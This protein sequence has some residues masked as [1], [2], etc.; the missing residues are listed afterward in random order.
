ML[1]AVHTQTAYSIKDTSGPAAAL[2]YME[3]KLHL[4]DYLPH[5]PLL[6]WQVLAEMSMANGDSSRASEI[7][8][9]IL[10]TPV[11]HVDD[12]VEPDVRSWAENHRQGTAQRETKSSGCFIA[13]AVYGN[14]D[15]SQVALLRQFRDERLV[16]TPSGRLFIR[17]YYSFSPAAAAV[18]RRSTIARLLAKSFLVMPALLLAHRRL[19]SGRPKDNGSICAGQPDKTRQMF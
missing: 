16:L 15:C 17:L 6:L 10:Q 9:R 19:R 12:G 2:A 8:Q 3:E 7:C 5:P 18:V 4:Y 11:S 13:T 14:A 1:A